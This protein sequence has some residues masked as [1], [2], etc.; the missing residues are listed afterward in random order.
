M[1]ARLRRC[2]G[3]TRRGQ[4]R[5]A[6]TVKRSASS[7]VALRPYPFWLKNP[8]SAGGPPPRARLHIAHAPAV[9]GVACGRLAADAAQLRLGAV[10]VA[11]RAAIAAGLRFGMATSTG[12]STWRKTWRTMTR[13]S[14]TSGRMGTLVATLRAYDMFIR[15]RVR[16]AEWLL[17]PS[18]VMLRQAPLARNLD[19]RRPTLAKLARHRP[20]ITNFEQLEPE[21]GRTW[22]KL[23]QLRLKLTRFART[24]LNLCRSHMHVALL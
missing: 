20:I 8:G 7:A 18:E 4:D 15:R 11:I 10:R 6:A 12:Q 17:H 14:T 9:A 3:R 22:P 13:A 5:R 1:R 16:V 24:R 23:R 19:R 21:V 2:R